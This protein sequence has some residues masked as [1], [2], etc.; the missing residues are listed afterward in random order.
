MSVTVGSHHF[1]NAIVDSKQ[2]HVKST[3]TQVKNEHI[4]LAFFLVHSILVKRRDIAYEL[5]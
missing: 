4:F 3:A 1:K 5:S 2:R